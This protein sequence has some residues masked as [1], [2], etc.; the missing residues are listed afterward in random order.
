[1]QIHHLGPLFHH[2]VVLDVELASPDAALADAEEHQGSDANGRN[3]GATSVDTDLG[4]LRQPCPFLGEAFI[5][6][7]EV[8]P[9]G[10]ISAK[11]TI[12]PAK[13][14]KVSRLDTYGTM[15]MLSHDP[16]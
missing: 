16:L 11:R 8:L 1:M 15:S 6:S 3:G 14:N 4:S 12:S 2:L 9:S 5:L 13:R 7:I 10:R